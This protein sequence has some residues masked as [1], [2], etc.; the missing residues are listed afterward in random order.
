MRRSRGR[1]ST[2]PGTH[3][4]GMHPGAGVAPPSA[5]KTE[6]IVT[7]VTCSRTVLGEQHVARL[8][9]GVGDGVRVQVRHAARRLLH[10][11]QP[12]PRRPRVGRPV[13]RRAARHG[14]ARRAPGFGWGWSVLG[15]VGE[16]EPALHRHVRQ[17]ERQVDER[18]AHLV[19]ARVRVQARAGA[20]VGVGV[21]IRTNGPRTSRR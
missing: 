11:K 19:R 9:V 13:R 18:P 15:G 6:I 14:T 10:E 20:R 4:T 16:L 2:L 7:T 12:T 21:G 3:H 17:L 1:P 5:S 8:E